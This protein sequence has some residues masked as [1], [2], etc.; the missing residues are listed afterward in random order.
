MAVAVL[1]FFNEAKENVNLQNRVRAA[2]SV[3]SVLEIARVE[4]YE[5]TALELKAT[6]DAQTTEDCAC[7]GL[8]HNI[9]H[10][11]GSQHKA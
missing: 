7:N 9:T 4:G 11:G 1:D 8:L 6:L 2:T 3:K 5:F 10:C